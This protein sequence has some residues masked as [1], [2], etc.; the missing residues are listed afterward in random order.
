[1]TNNPI[2][3]KTFNLIAQIGLIGTQSVQIDKI[4]IHVPATKMRNYIVK[5]AA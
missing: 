4:N 2:L 5:I 3:N 1:M